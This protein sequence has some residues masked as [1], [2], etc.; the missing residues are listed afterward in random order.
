MKIFH[1]KVVALE[2]Q[3]NSFETALC[4]QAASSSTGIAEIRNE[5]GS[6]LLNKVA[7]NGMP[8]KEFARKYN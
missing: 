3:D 7:C 1:V 5:H 6:A 8:L 4:V 2:A